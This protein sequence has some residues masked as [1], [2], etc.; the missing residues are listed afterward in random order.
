MN[1]NLRFCICLIL[2]GALCIFAQAVDQA[3]FIGKTT[4]DNKGGL[5][6]SVIDRT[7]TYQGIL[8]DNLGDPVPDGSYSLTFRIYKL[9]AGGLVLW[10]SPQIPVLTSSGYFSAILSSI[11]LPFDTTYYLSV[12]VQGD[13]EMSR[14]M[15]T[16]SPYSASSD[17]ANYAKAGAGDGKWS[18]RITDSADTT[19]ESGSRWGLARNGN[20]LWGNADSTHTNLGVASTTG[21]EGSNNKY[22]TIAGG[23]NNVAAGLEATIGG[24]TGNVSNGEKSFVGGG[25]LNTATGWGS[26]VS[27]GYGN[28]ASNS[29][30]TVSGGENDTA[31]GRW[32]VVAGGY[33]NA[34]RNQASTISGGLSNVTQANYSTIGG[35]D[36]NDVSGD[37]STISGGSY[38]KA[39]GYTSNIGGGYG[40]L[41]SNSYSCIA[42]G[43]FDTVSGAWAV[44]SGGYKNAAKSDFSAVLSGRSNNAAD[45]AALVAGGSYNSASEEYSIVSGGSQNLAGGRWSTIG[46]GFIDTANGQ[47]SVVA[48]GFH[49]VVSTMSSAIGGGDLNIVGGASSVIAGGTANRVYG[50][51]SAV[52]GGSINLVNGICSA[53]GGG[54]ADSVFANYS[55]VFSGYHNRVGSSNQDSCGFIG[56]GRENFIGGDYGSIG[57]GYQNYVDGCGSV[58]GGGFADSTKG[59]YAGVF[60]GSKNLAGDAPGDTGAFVGGGISNK[61]VSKYATVAGGWG[62]LASNLQATIGGGERDTASNQWATIAGGA[63]NIASGFGSMIPGGSDN[64]AGGNRSFAAGLGANATHDGSFVWADDTPV[65]YYSDRAKQAKFRSGGGVKFDLNA[66]RWVEFYDDGVDRLINVSNSAYLSRGGTWTNA[67]DRNLKENFTQIVGSDLLQKICQLPI[68]RWNYKTEDRTTT[69]IGP[70]AQ[71]FNALFEVGNDTTS[72]STIDPAGVALGGVKELM[73]KIET[74]EKQNAE[75]LIRIEHLEKNSR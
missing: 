57:G 63:H 8:K 54:Y 36:H 43:L 18:F 22:C 45:T 59:V 55:G 65:S 71:D 9:P 68:M 70:T 2:L 40:N 64:V 5:L 56:G 39:S 27:G 74:L 21:T 32:S 10:T 62:N 7:I 37:L 31:S 14:Q 6:A 42:G 44:V 33:G 19:L 47:Y 50:S 69:H 17:T 73:K 16:M 20:M 75:L 46:G 29:E 52:S 13:V 66:S 48:G 35:G 61:A 3:S 51:Y 34:A 1:L 28:L 11:S 58:I 67:S 23:Y 49:N 60:S 12:Q 24:G 25:G 38:N 15:M 41:A 4:P 72:I 26:V 53:A 30:A